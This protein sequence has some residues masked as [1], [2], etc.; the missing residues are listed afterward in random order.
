VADVEAELCGFDINDT[1]EKLHS[2]D[3]ASS[4]HLRPG[5]SG[6]ENL[7]QDNALSENIFLD[8]TS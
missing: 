7:T 6:V 4:L 8:A 3:A 2:R 5:Q 1:R